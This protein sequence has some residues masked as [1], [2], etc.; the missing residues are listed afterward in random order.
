MHPGVKLPED[1]GTSW[2][3]D[4]SSIVLCVPDLLRRSAI[5]QKRKVSVYIHDISHPTETDPVFMGAVR[6]IPT[7]P[8]DYSNTGRYKKE[9]SNDMELVYVEEEETITMQLLEEF[10]LVEEL[11]CLHDYSCYQETISIANREWIVTV[12][13]EDEPD[14]TR[15]I[16]VVMIGIVVFAAS[17]G[18]AVWVIANDRRNR[19]YAAIKSKAAAERTSLI[20]D[21]ANNAARTERELN[22]FLAHE[23]RNP[24]AAAMAATQ[25]LR[26][27]LDRSRKRTSTKS[28]AV[29]FKD[30]D[31]YE[32]E[33]D[34]INNDNSDDDNDDCDHRQV[35][36]LES[37][38][39]ALNSRD[40]S[41]KS[42]T[43]SRLLQAREDVRVVDHALRFINDLLRNMLDMHRASSRQLQV[44]M[45]PV[46]LLRDVIE[47][48]AGMLQRG[49]ERNGSR[50]S[51]ADDK[52]QILVD[53]PENLFVMT[54]P[55]RLKQVLLNLGRNSVKFIHEGFIRLRAEVVVVDNNN[56]ATTINGCDPVDI[57][58][59]KS[60]PPNSIVRLYV[61]DS[62]S[63]IP[64]EKRE[65]LFAKYQE[66]LDLLSQGTVRKT[67]DVYACCML[68]YYDRFYFRF[69]HY[70]H[71]N[72]L[73]PLLLLL[74]IILN[75]YFL[76]Q[77]IGLHLCKNLVDLMGGEISLDNEYDSGVFGYSGARFIIDLQSGPVDL[78]V[79][80]F[81]LFDGDETDD[82]GTDDDV[83]NENFKKSEGSGITH[84]M[85]DD[86]NSLPHELPETLKVLF[87]D[88]D[89]VLR[90]LFTRSIKRVCPGWTIR[91]AANG[92]TAILLAE[93]EDFDLIFCDMYM[94]S[95]EK[96]LLGTETVAEL[97]AKG[98]TCR[99]CGL[100]ANDKEIEFL[101]A[102]SDTFH[103]KPMPCEANALKQTLYRVLY[104][105]HRSYH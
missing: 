84:G 7:H 15:S 35:V 51:R 61:E 4:F 52:V 80:T 47:P 49:G 95:V 86:M 27:E 23:V 12:L 21:N 10:P 34:S 100:S 62:G 46:D 89:S 24:L 44:N 3:K 38:V 11:Q 71:C 93:E 98:I 69:P 75:W 59:G 30:E 22:D 64:F 78:P 65:R 39:Q 54:D 17:I 50:K 40:C 28:I 6:L 66:S 37:P 20:L 73:P 45:S 60:T 72:S 104:A 18:L 96:Q 77:G 36:S 67:R 48:V 1:D 105:E 81:P 102:G 88:D 56:G 91:E 53:C 55:L 16:L 26:T 94:A 85:D 79:I 42:D 41:T 14:R 33:R 8:D 32:S 13:D 103:I 57:E 74:P 90:K 83:S 31:G 29:H 58:A 97:R 9:N 76:I 2:P 19:R 25:F 5:H 70:F 87:V 43:S 99:I 82:D 92:E 68:L 63:G 101:E